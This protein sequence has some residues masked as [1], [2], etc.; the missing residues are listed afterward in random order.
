MRGDEVPRSYVRGRAVV[1]V[2]VV[3]ALAALVAVALDAHTF[4]WLFGG[5]QAVVR[6]IRGW[7]SWWNW[8]D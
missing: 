4:H 8:G 3:V 5:A 6:R 7:L 2:A 1:L